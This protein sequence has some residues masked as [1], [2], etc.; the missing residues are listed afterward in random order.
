MKARLAYVAIFILSFAILIGSCQSDS[1]LE[2][3]RYYSNGK[4]LYDAHCQNCHGS[5]G[6][7]LGLLIP[8][9]TDTL[10]LQKNRNNLACILKKGISTPIKV[11]GKTFFGEMP[12][13]PRLANIEIAELTTYITNTFGNKQGIFTAKNAEHDL[14]DCN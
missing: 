10:F 11:S 7:G 14:L 9:L 6:L 3:A 8:P 13:N 4:Q 2:Y 1:E 5:T 12:A